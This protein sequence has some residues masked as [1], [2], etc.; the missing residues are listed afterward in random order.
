LVLKFA[1][2]IASCSEHPPP[3]GPPTFC[4]VV[5]TK[6][7]GCSIRRGE[8]FT[9]LLKDVAFAPGRAAALPLE[10]PIAAALARIGAFE[11]DVLAKEMRRATSAIETNT[12]TE[13]E[14]E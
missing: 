5:V 1:A 12:T 3:G 6:I 10:A 7:L 11:A 2:Y 4:A 14:R 8:P 13:I 9:C